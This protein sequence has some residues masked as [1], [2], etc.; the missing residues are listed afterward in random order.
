ML[1]ISAIAFGR[2]SGVNILFWHR[3]GKCRETTVREPQRGHPQYL[4]NALAGMLFVVAVGVL[5]AESHAQTPCPDVVFDCLAC[6]YRAGVPL[7]RRFIGGL[8]AVPPM[9]G[10][11]YLGGFKRHFHHMLVAV[12]LC[13]SLRNQV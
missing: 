1:V 9:D 12:V 7:M 6:P 2:G 8:I 10:G 3:L 11:Q 5:L 4:K 13:R